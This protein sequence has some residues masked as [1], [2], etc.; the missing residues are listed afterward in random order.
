MF[1]TRKR[2]ALLTAALGTLAACKSSKPEK[3][4]E[5]KAVPAATAEA[6]PEAKRDPSEP[7][8]A[9]PTAAPPPA[10][11]GTVLSPPPEGA[12]PDQAIY[13]YVQSCDEAHPC[14]SALQTEA[15]IHCRELSIGTRDRGWRL[16]SRHEADR[17]AGLEGLADLAGYHWTRTPYEEDMMQVY[18]VDP[19]GEGPTTTIPRTRKPF[20]V[21]CVY[22][23]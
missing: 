5:A 20:K 15:E 6:A 4:T 11:E 9:R 7:F 10:P 17:F 19:S 13:L 8:V 16:P 3:P 23:P 22:E 18:I 1:D 12:P 14:P 21:R 2:I